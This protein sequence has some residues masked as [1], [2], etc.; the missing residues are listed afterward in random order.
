MPPG[1]YRVFEKPIWTD[2]R[3][4]VKGLV[5]TVFLGFVLRSTEKFLY[6][7]FI[8]HSLRTCQGGTG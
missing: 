2:R 4:G 6:Q 5:G 7:P 8:L 1:V 3:G